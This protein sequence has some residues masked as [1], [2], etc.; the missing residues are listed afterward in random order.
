MT[1]TIE[2]YGALCELREFR[3]NGIEADYSDFGCKRDVNPELAEP[4]CCGNMRFI[5]GV[6]SDS[7]LNKYRITP[8][9]W[10][11]VVSKLESTLSFG[12]CGWCE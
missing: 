4:Y 1:L 8:S 9:E 12:C 10:N 2:P 3:I 7:V 6:M 11:Q 5:P